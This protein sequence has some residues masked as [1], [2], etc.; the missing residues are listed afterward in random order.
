M[1][2]AAGGHDAD[3]LGNGDAAACGVFPKRGWLIKKEERGRTASF[4]FEQL[5]ERLAVV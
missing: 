5:M 2:P 4:F 1:P 3:P